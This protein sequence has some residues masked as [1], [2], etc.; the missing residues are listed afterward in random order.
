MPDLATV[1]DLSAFAQLNLDPD[2]AAATFL[3]K[4]ASG[5]VRAYLQQDLS[6]TDNDIVLFD[7]VG[8]L[9]ELTNLPVL[10]VS[11]VEITNDSGSTW[12]TLDRSSYTLSR[13]AGIIAARPFTGIQWPSDP[14]SWRVTY[15]HGYD[16]IPDEIKGVVCGVAA[17]AYSSPVGI[18]MERTGQRQVKYALES[19]GFSGLEQIVL[20]NYRLARL[21]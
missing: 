4:V 21:A 18:D 14:E 17:R 5:M 16:P 20:D 11:L 9:V 7:P 1:P 6:R 2:D 3:L 12:T 19:G 8:T 10:S 13:R 15:S